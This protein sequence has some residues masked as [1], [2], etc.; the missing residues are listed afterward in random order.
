MKDK[1]ET[2]IFISYAW[3]GGAEK[4]EWIRDHIVNSLSWE[5]SLFWDRDSI[6]FGDSVDATIQKA[7]A[8]RPLKVFCLCDE[9][10][11]YSAKNTGSGLHRELQMLSALSSDPDV[12]IIPIVLEQISLAELPAPLEGRAYLDLTEFRKR[13]IFLGSAMYHLAGDVTQSEMLRWINYS[14]CKDD[15][16][17]SAREYFDRTPVRFIGNA[18]TH[19]VSTNF[20][21]PLLA[22]QWMWDSPEWGYMLS[23]EYDTYCP[24]KGCWHWDHSSPGRSMQVL[25]T[26]MIAHFFPSDAKEEVQWAIEE[27]GKI[28]A[29]HFIS[30][31]RKDEPF[32]LNVNEI[33]M[34]LF[35]EDGG[36][37][38]LEHLLKQYA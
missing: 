3:G 22:P 32:V 30:M 33:I 24:T 26:A 5:Y 8:S 20:M 6:T 14:L 36:C 35:H 25:G 37:R 23:D 12:K 21:Q 19:K 34:H 7:L 17:K 11:L 31:I 10:Y 1:S 13:G 29:V 16:Y 2:T 9:D 38:A 4:K 28:L 27:A 18:R 15:L